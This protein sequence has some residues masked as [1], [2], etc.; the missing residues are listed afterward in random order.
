[1]RTYPALP[2]WMKHQ[3]AGLRTRIPI[4][5]PSRRDV[6]LRRLRLANFGSSLANII[7]ALDDDVLPLAKRP[8]IIWTLLELFIRSLGPEAEGL[9]EIL[10]GTL[11]AVRGY[12]ERQFIE[13]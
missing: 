7:L 5:K 13:Y 10:D 1:M 2:G 11:E 8:Q 9:P 3:V 6:H 12:T 4:G